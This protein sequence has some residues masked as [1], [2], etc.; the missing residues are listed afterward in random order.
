VLIADPDP[1][2]ASMIRDLVELG[3][4]EAVITRNG[5]EAKAMLRRRQL[6]VL[7]VANLSLPR[8][9]GFA[10]L[11]D[12][13]RMAG[14]AG[15][16]VVVISSSK[17]LSGVAISSS[18]LP[19]SRSRTMA[20]EVNSTMV[21]ERITPISAGTICT[22][23]RRS[24]LSL[25]T[26]PGRLMVGAAGTLLAR[27]VDLKSYEG[28]ATFAV[29]DAG[30]AELLRPALYG[31]FHRIVAIAPRPGAEQRYE[32]VGPICESADI[33]GRDRLLPPLEVGDVLAILDAGAYGSVMASTYNRHMLPAEVLVDGPSWRV[34]RRRQT[35]DDQLSLEQ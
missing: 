6:P 19:R 18:R 31:A 3:G 14:G 15:P 17:E 22:A 5:D 35:V 13:R 26:E 28:G 30:M 16:P 29:L 7:V 11:A 12:L 8:L 9:D 24:G 23:V 32:V 2:R 34:I 10:L 33:F 4:Y 20:P 1:K 27:L 21:M 25:V